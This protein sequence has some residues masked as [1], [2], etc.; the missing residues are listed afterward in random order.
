M[1]KVLVV[2]DD[3]RVLA[4][5]RQHLQL[6]GFSVVEASDAKEAWQLLLEERPDAA[7]IDLN[8]VPSAT[9]GAWWQRC[10]RTADSPACRRW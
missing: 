8:S 10:G 3:L 6:E 7:L 5:I 2:E 9:A 4:M 1:P